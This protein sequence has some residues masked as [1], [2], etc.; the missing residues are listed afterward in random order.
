VNEL[1]SSLKGTLDRLRFRSTPSPNDA[2]TRPSQPNVPGDAGQLANCTAAQDDWRHSPVLVA[3]PRPPAPIPPMPTLD[4]VLSALDSVIEWSIETSSRLGYFA[5]P[6]KRITIA[7]SAAV[8]KIP[9][10]SQRQDT[11]GRTS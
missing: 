3:T 7:A 5:A 8:T 6:Y 1:V 4:A 10:G 11:L 9:D 2:P